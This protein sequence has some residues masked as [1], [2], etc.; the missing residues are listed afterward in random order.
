MKRQ[1]DKHKNEEKL[2][3]EAQEHMKN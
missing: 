2:V 1:Y 3:I